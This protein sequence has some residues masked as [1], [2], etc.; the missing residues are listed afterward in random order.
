VTDRSSWGQIFLPFSLSLGLG[1]IAVHTAKHT[2]KHSVTR[3]AT[4]F[5]HEVRSLSLSLYL[6]SWGLHCGTQCKAHCKTFCNTPCNIF[7]IWGQIFLFMFFKKDHLR[8][9]LYMNWFWR[10]TNCSVHNCA[11]AGEVHTHRRCRA[12]QTLIQSFW[13]ETSV[14]KNLTGDM[15]AIFAAGEITFSFFR[16]SKRCSFWSEEKEGNYAEKQS[17]LDFSFENLQNMAAAKDG[18]CGLENISLCTCVFL[19]VEV[20]KCTHKA[21]VLHILAWPFGSCTLTNAT[22]LEIC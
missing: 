8:R 3:P 14:L 16:D 13:K 21:R 18:S 12:P 5:R 6:S 15:Y 17:R 11:C 1:F 10:G 22:C 4:Y 7:S 2:A 9:K 19:F 20:R